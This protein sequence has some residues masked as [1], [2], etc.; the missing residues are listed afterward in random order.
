MSDLPVAVHP[1]YNQ[2]K[3]YRKA[4]QENVRVRR[5]V[6]DSRP[7]YK[8]EEH[9]T[10]AQCSLSTTELSPPHNISSLSVKTD[11]VGEA[12]ATAQAGVGSEGRLHRASRHWLGEAV[13]RHR[14]EQ[15]S[16]RGRPALPPASTQLLGKAAVGE[17]T[18]TGSSKWSISANDERW[19]GRRGEPTTA[20]QRRSIGADDEQWEADRRRRS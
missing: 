9:V 4:P 17:S 16:A 20:E 8:G 3:R 6:G 2:G 1:Y 13:R 12:A 15:A 5:P 14:V 11:A 19:V 10:T 18:A 7:A